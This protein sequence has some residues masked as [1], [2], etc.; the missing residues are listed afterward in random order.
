M[1]QDQESLTPTAEF[2]LHLLETDGPLSRQDLLDRLDRHP[3]TVDRA[4]RQL[5]ETGRVAQTRNSDDL[6]E[7]VVYSTPPC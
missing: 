6:R 4:L 5:R 3:D 7:V 2:V 1:E